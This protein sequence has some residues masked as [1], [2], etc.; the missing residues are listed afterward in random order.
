MFNSAWEQ[1]L[2]KSFPKN[3]PNY[4]ER[5]LYVNLDERRF[6]E[7]YENAREGHSGRS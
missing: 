7:A 4:R 2:L 1:G 3:E 6:R 5:G